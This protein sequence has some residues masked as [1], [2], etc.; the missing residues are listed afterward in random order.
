MATKHTKSKRQ[1]SAKEEVLYSYLE[2]IHFNGDFSASDFTG[3][4]FDKHC[5]GSKQCLHS[6]AS[7]IGTLCND[8]GEENENGAR[9]P[10]LGIEAEVYL[11]DLGGHLDM[12][13]V[14]MG[15]WAKSNPSQ[16]VNQA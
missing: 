5:G 1:I 14:G 6:S 8:L 12:D 3:R 2:M 15:G 16:T 9:K 13:F 11:G 7:E 4:R 10:H